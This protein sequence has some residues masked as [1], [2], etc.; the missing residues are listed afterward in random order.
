M[1]KNKKNSKVKKIKK[2]KKVTRKKV[3]RTVKVKVPRM[4]L[5]EDAG[6][7]LKGIAHKA[8]GK[9]V[10]H[11]GTKVKGRLPKF[12]HGAVDKVGNATR[13]FGERQATNQLDRGVAQVRGFVNRK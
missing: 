8:I 12:L 11:L 3:R 7:A 4:G 1:K 13:V 10:N 5:V 2:V 6:N 9:T